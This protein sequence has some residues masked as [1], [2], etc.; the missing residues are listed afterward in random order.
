[1][2]KFIS[3]ECQ[4]IEPAMNVSFK[5]NSLMVNFPLNSGGDEETIWILTIEKLFCLSFCL[6]VKCQD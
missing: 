1:M 6:L 2:A 3:F 5:K 4:V